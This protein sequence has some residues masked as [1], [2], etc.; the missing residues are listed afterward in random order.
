MRPLWRL[1]LVGL[2]AALAACEPEP[3]PLPVVPPP[4]PDAQTGGFSPLSAESA[5]AANAPLRYGLIGT[6]PDL[7]L[8]EASAQ[9][10][11]LDT[12]PESQELGVRYDIVAA[13]GAFPGWE[14]SPVAPTLG[15]LVNPARPPLDNSTLREIVRRSIAPTEL[16]NALA[17]PGALP[18]P[19][20]Y[21]TTAEARAALANAGWPDGFAARLGILPMPGGEAVAARLAAVNIATTHMT[22]DAAALGAALDAG[23]LHLA[24]VTWTNAEERAEWAA[25]VGA[26]NVVDLV[27]L[28]ISYWARD[29]LN[30]TLTPGGW[31]VPAR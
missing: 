2:C 6:T 21:I 18:A 17:L 30:I 27:T 13:Y 1:A 8:L 19:L 20:E 5:D 28:P 11:L 3:T 29:G 15:L 12:P 22:L 10:T 25:R 9:V 14:V 23:Q 16:T 4:P 24:L 26:E 7:A 31:P